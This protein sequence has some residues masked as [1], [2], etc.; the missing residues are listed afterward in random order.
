MKGFNW[1]SVIHN[2]DIEDVRERWKR[3]IE[4]KSRY[5]EE[6]RIVCSDGKSVLVR[7]IGYPIIE[8]G[9]LREFYGTVNLIEPEKN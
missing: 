1:E 9:E 6:Q 8:N 4:K 2:D 5:A 7:V 3:A